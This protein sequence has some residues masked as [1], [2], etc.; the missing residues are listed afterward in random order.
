MFKLFAVTC[1]LATSI[2]QPVVTD[3]RNVVYNGI[4]RNGIEL[5][6]GIPYGQ[7]T[8]GVNRFKPPKPHVFKSGSVFNATEYGDACPQGPDS[9]PTIGR[10]KVSENCLHLDI[11]RP[12]HITKKSKLPVMVYL[13]GGGFVAGD[14]QGP[15]TAPDGL[16]LQSQRNGLPIIEVALTYRLGGTS[17]LLFYTRIVFDYK[18]MTW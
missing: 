9:N 7:D 18:L 11:A 14:T 10:V 16:V 2:A 12:Q 1:L 8:S 13:P 3:S 17:L 4:Q 15:W 5:F 6:L